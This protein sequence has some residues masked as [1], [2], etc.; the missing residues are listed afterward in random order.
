MRMEDVSRTELPY[1]QIE[2]RIR[3]DLYERKPLRTQERVFDDF[4]LS[5]RRCFWIR[6]QDAEFVEI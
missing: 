5:E 6:I 3:Q 2:N 4:L 1:I